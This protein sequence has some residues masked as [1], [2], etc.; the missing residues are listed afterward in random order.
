MGKAFKATG[1]FSTKSESDEGTMSMSGHFEMAT[2]N[3]KFK[4]YMNVEES[5]QGMEGENLILSFQNDTNHVTTIMCMKSVQTQNKW[6]CFKMTTGT[7]QV[8]EKMGGTG[9]AENP[10]TTWEEYKNRFTYEGLKEIHGVM[11]HCFYAN[12]Q[13]NDTHVEE[14][15]CFDPQLNFFRYY[16]SK[17]TNP[18]GTTEIELFVDSVSF[19]VSDSE[20]VPPAKPRSFPGIPSTP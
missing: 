9:V 8:E 18:D 17:R 3:E 7:S 5:S 15:V 20:F 1:I 19:S 16:W 12:Y 2:M 13:E 6:M 4:F 10:T 14:R 11:L